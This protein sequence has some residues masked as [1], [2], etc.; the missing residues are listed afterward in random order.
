MQIIKRVFIFIFL[1]IVGGCASGPE[2]STYSV[3]NIEKADATNGVIFGKICGGQG[4]TF[5]NLETSNEILNFGG[6]PE[7]ALK[8]PPGKYSLLS[9]G[10]GIGNFESSNPFVFEL[11]AREVI[12]IGSILPSWYYGNPKYLTWCGKELNS[13]VSKK[14]YVLKGLLKR[15]EEASVQ[16]ANNKDEAILAVKKRYPHLDLSGSITRLMQ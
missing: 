16:I 2:N 5:K 14:E 6:S 1:V 10:S 4:I 8:L 12:Y 11:H 7:F 3:G 13:I 15:T 9:I